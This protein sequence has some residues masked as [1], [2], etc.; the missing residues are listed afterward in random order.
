ML[1]AGVFHMFHVFVFHIINNS[2]DSLDLSIYFL[3]VGCKEVNMK[4]FI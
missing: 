3:Y 1:T 4:E 2:F